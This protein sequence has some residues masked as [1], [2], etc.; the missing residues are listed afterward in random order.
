[1]CGQDKAVYVNWV[2]SDPIGIK[3]N[4]SRKLLSQDNLEM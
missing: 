4:I 2:T 3:G 1:M